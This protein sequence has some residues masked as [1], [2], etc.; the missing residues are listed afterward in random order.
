MPLDDGSLDGSPVEG[1]ESLDLSLD[2]WDFCNSDALSSVCFG[3][4][5]LSFQRAARETA[6]NLAVAGGSL[7]GYLW[8]P[9]IIQ[10]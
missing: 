2:L 6:C 5:A 1:A 8:V 10:N 7:M 9:P 3:K 4:G